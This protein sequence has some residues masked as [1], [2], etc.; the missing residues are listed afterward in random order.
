MKKTKGFPLNPSFPISDI[1]ICTSIRWALFVS[2]NHP[3]EF[4]NTARPTAAAKVQVHVAIPPPVTAARFT[5]FR[6]ADVGRSSRK[7]A[8]L[9]QPQQALAVSPE[10]VA[11]A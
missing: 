10:V 3:C 8:K 5:G 6:Q 4:T 2:T 9:G 7:R 1:E 11:V